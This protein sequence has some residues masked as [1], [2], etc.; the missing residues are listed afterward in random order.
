MPWPIV[1][2]T[3]YFEEHT[4]IVLD[5][6]ARLDGAPE[7]QANANVVRVVD[8]ELDSGGSGLRQLRLHRCHCPLLIACSRSSCILLSK[9]NGLVLEGARECELQFCCWDL[10]LDWHLHWSPHSTDFL[11]LVT[12][13][14][15][16]SLHDSSYFLTC[17]CGLGHNPLFDCILVFAHKVG[18]DSSPELEVTLVNL[19]SGII[20]ELEESLIEVLLRQRLFSR[21]VVLKDCLQ[22]GQTPIEELLHLCDALGVRSSECLE[23]LHR[24][25]VAI[26]GLL[27]LLTCESE[28]VQYLQEL[29]EQQHRMLLVARL[30]TPSANK[31]VLTALGVD[32]DLV[33][34]LSLMTLNLTGGVE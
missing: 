11:D 21:T 19:H 9:L 2:F 5:K 8:L 29:S 34:R 27:P 24:V 18:G 6:E 1:L 28:V 16:Q 23:A 14:L 30:N 3:E 26:H 7:T 12:D 10:D 17:N 33:E 32:A 15:L 25:A 20:L 22:Q 13:R 4:C 31:F